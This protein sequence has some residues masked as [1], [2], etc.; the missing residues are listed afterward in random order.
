MMARRWSAGA[1]SLAE[2]GIDAVALSLRSAL[3]F[4]ATPRGR[5]SYPTTSHLVRGRPDW[6]STALRVGAGSERHLPGGWPGAILA[7]SISAA[8]CRRASRQD[9][10][11]PSHTIF[12]QPLRIAAAR[13]G[14][15]EIGISGK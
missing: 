4:E 8:R 15:G 7:P 14:G 3:G 1:A 6:T 2:V 10:G 9:A 12:S 5:V 13:V 11:A